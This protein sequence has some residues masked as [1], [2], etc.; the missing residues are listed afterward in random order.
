MTDAVVSPGAL[1]PVPN[2]VATAA[3]NQLSTAGA[4]AAVIVLGRAGV[5]REAVE[6]LLR[7]A[8]LDVIDLVRMDAARAK[9]GRSIVV[10]VLVEPTVDDWRGAQALDARVVVVLDGP[11]SDERTLQLLVGGADA[12]LHAGVEVERLIAAVRVVGIGNPFLG[13]GQA[14]VL[15]DRLRAGKV[16]ADAA[17][18]LTRRESEILLSIERGES[19]RETA[20]GLAIST[21]TVQNLQ[22]RLFRK[23]GARNRLQAIARA[24]ELGLVE[25]AGR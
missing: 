5:E 8:G 18:T 24:Y 17:P 13:A 23:L 2:V 14:R 11:A 4:P 9:G 16:A 15:V 21:K 19:V 10:A 20:A 3:A 22:S 7:S 12:V 1:A 25:D 6:I